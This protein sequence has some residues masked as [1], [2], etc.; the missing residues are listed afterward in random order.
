MSTYEECM[1]AMRLIG[2]NVRWSQRQMAR[3]VGLSVLPGFRITSVVGGEATRHVAPSEDVTALEP[4]EAKYI[5]GLT[6]K[7]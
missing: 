5:A 2:R 4:G 7:R 1:A 3:E 6:E